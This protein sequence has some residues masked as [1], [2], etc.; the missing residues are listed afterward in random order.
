MRLDVLRCRPSGASEGLKTGLESLEPAELAGAGGLGEVSKEYP[1]ASGTRPSQSF[2]P[3][4]EEM[5]LC[6]TR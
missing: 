3:I 6:L 2:L 4:L 5:A 1:Q